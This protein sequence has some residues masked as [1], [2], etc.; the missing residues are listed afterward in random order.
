MTP[1]RLITQ[2]RDVLQDERAAL[3]SGR[4]SDL[5]AVGQ[6]K[7][8]LLEQAQGQ[9]IA[10]DHPDWADIRARNQQN[11]ALLQAAQRGLAE[12]RARLMQIRDGG[13]ALKTYDRQGRSVEHARAPKLVKKRA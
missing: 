13:L 1:E 7:L 10:S 5:D 12:S 3:L 11:G 8:D 9:D 6:R 2:L 4:I